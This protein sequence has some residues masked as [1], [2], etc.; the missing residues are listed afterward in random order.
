MSRLSFRVKWLSCQYAVPPLW[1]SMIL[2]SSVPLH[3]LFLSQVRSLASLANA[4]PTHARLPQHRLSCTLASLLGFMSFLFLSCNSSSLADRSLCTNQS[5]CVVA[6]RTD[7]KHFKLLLV[8]SRVAPFLFWVRAQK[9]WSVAQCHP[10]KQRQAPH[11][12]RLRAPLAGTPA[13]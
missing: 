4:S 13:G 1:S 5:R 2:T 10:R 8:H 11:R 6:Q 9:S 12:L 7:A 3:L